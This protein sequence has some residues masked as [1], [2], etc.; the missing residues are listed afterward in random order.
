ME[1]P[2]ITRAAA[3]P[4]PVPTIAKKG[5]K[6]WD[7]LLSKIVPLLQDPKIFPSRFSYGESYEEQ[8]E[9]LV[10]SVLGVLLLTILFLLA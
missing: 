2:I 9:V 5:G 4:S 3:A 1:A 6:T 10:A 7:L 8:A